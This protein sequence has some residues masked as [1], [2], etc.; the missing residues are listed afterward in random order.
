MGMLSSWFSLDLG[1]D[2]GTAT[3]LVYVRGEGI[4]LCEPSVVAIR[5]ESRKVLAVGAE[6]K[7]ML[8]RTPGDI[9]AIRPMKDGVIADF[10]V[11][12]TMISYFIRRA[13]T[14]RPALRAARTRVV[15]AVPSGIT[16][17]E[18]RAVEE[19]AQQAGAHR[20]RLIEEPF[21]AAIGA[22]LPVTEPSGSMI[23]D[24][25]GGTTEMAVISLGGI[26]VSRSER[27]AGDRMDDAIVQHIK[28]K[29]N[30]LIGD[31]T[32]EDIK[33]K[34][35]SAD[36]LP[37]EVSM[38][39]KGRD[40]VAGMP[41][42]LEITSEEIREALT[43]PVSTIINAVKSTLERTPPELAADIVDSGIV[44]AGGGAQLQGLD[45]VLMNETGLNV[46]LADNPET[47]IVLGTGKTLEAM[48]T[49]LQETNGTGF[50]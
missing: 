21:A 29:Y 4:V 24:V 14:V 30:L 1:I 25:G 11:T 37:R 3:T 12:R 9:V 8:G 50:R 32:A 39:I 48:E 5:K 16:E 27:T 28:R 17:V 33:I 42:T 47:A 49:L 15:I 45:Q 18:R 46:R 13:R 36:Y 31:R 26:V 22:G 38:I 34:I 44:M 10:G 43:E 35:G 20:V 41:R 40:M 6:A 7:R 2:L 23:I 19:S